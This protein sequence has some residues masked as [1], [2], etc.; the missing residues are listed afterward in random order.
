MKF[1]I[2]KIIEL[3]INPTVIYLG[4]GKYFV[5]NFDYGWAFHL[6]IAINRIVFSVWKYYTGDRWTRLCFTVGP[7]KFVIKI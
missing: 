2:P 5:F 3:V 6:G 4:I 1:L 7:Y